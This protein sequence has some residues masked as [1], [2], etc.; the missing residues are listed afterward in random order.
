M[1]RVSDRLI[2][3]RIAVIGTGNMGRALLEGLRLALEEVKDAGPDDAR[4]R[5]QLRRLQVET[6]GVERVP[7]IFDKDRLA[8]A[9]AQRLDADA[10][11][12]R[13]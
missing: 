4:A 3:K 9:A 7:R 2:K 1:A 13:E 11:G 12:A 6:D 5:T 10:A 8:R